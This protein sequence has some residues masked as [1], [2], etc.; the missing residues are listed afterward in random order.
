MSALILRSQ[1]VDLQAEKA[2]ATL[3]GLDGSVAYMAEPITPLAVFAASA[4]RLRY[5]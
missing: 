3:E 5:R 4:Y 1:L 2:L